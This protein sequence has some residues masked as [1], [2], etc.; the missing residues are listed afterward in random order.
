MKFE[1]IFM[2]QFKAILYEYNN[3]FTLEVHKEMCKAPK[4]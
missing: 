4:M 3:L 1:I 2:E